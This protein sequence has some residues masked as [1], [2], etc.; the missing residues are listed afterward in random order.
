LKLN[1]IMSLFRSNKLNLRLCE[2]LVRGLR[3]G[4]K[5][6]GKNKAGN[7][8]VNVVA[9]IGLYYPTVV[10]NRVGESGKLSEVFVGLNKM[11]I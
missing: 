9:L 5:F 7:F 10:Q 2:N 6:T 1:P 4:H 11:P 8:T 3:I